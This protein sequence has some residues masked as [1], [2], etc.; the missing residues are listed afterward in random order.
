ML[1]SIGSQKVRHD[2]ATE[3]NCEAWILSLI[4]CVSFR[5]V[6]NLS[7]ASLSSS[8]WPSLQDPTPRLSPSV[9]TWFSA[10]LHSL[11]E[12]PGATGGGGRQETAKMEGYLSWL[13]GVAEWARRVGR[14]LNTRRQILLQGKA[15]FLLIRIDQDEER[16]RSCLQMWISVIPTYQLI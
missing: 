14:Q 3:L 1:Q 15:V 2:Q 9:W 5:P 7:Q 8:T 6:S 10:A 11:S 13:L 4:S 16:E 12:A